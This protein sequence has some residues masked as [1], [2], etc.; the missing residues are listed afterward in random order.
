MCHVV[1]SG[2]CIAEVPHGRKLPVLK[3]L[4]FGFVDV[5]VVISY[6]IL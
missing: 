1:R 4:G 3:K 6:C 5:G 2:V